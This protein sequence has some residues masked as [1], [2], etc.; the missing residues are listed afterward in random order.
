VLQPVPTSTGRTTSLI[1]GIRG[2]AG[3][4]NQSHEV[5]PASRGSLT[6]DLDANLGSE[7]RWVTLDS[8]DGHRYLYDV[9]AD[10]CYDPVSEDWKLQIDG[11]GYR[12]LNIREF[13]GTAGSAARAATG[14][15]ATGPP[16]PGRSRPCARWP[17]KPCSIIATK[18]PVASERV[19]DGTPRCSPGT[20]HFPLGQCLGI[21]MNGRRQVTR[22]SSCPAGRPTSRGR[23]GW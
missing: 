7:D 4:G 10:R 3:C 11:Y 16:D 13:E 18:R 23:R 6:T 5:N 17:A 14:P 8:L 2:R 22:P 9:L 12:W 15:S 20:P 1:R 19:S 21:I